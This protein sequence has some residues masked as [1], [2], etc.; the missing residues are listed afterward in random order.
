MLADPDKPALIFTHNIVIWNHAIQKN[1]GFWLCQHPNSQQDVPCPERFNLDY[2][3]YWSPERKEPS[4]I[5]SDPDNP[6]GT[7][8]HSMSDWQKMGEDEHSINADARLADARY[9]ADNF[10]VQPGS[11]AEKIGFTAFDPKQAGLTTALPRP[12]VQPPAFPLEV[13]DP[14]DY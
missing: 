6:R 4:F 9:P 14:A 2:N 13:M 12:P 8:S 11:A 10:T 5:T 7:H 1:L 3:L